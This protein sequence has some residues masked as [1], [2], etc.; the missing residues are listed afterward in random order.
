MKKEP[1]SDMVNSSQKPQ[2]GALSMVT[3]QENS[4]QFNNNFFVSHNGGQLSSDSGLVP[5]M[6]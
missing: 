4:V 5:W 3:L 1:F 2:K 6:S